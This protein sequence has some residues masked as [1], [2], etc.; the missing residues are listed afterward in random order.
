MATAKKTTSKASSTSGAGKKASS[1]KSGSKKT[2]A[3]NTGA[4]K[5][6]AASQTGGVEPV[7]AEQNQT[8]L[9]G[10][11]LMLV[12][13]MLSLWFALIGL[14]VFGAESTPGQML[15]AVPAGLANITLALSAV[16]LGYTLY[17]ERKGRFGA[18]QVAGACFF[19]LAL[20]GLLHLPYFAVE[21]TAEASGLAQAW[22]AGLQG[23]GGSVC[24]FLVALL[25]CWLP[26]QAAPYIVLLA[27]LLLG[28]MLA[29]DMRIFGAAAKSWHKSRLAAR[30]KK[31]AAA[32]AREQAAA[33]AALQGPPKRP[34]RTSFEADDDTGQP[35]HTEKLEITLPPVITEYSGSRFADVPR[36]AYDHVTVGQMLGDDLDYGLPETNPTDEYASIHAGFTTI[37]RNQAANQV[38]QPRP[39]IPAQRQRSQPT[40]A[41]SPLRETFAQLAHERFLEDQ[42]EEFSETESAAFPLAAET[43]TVADNGVELTDNVAAFDEEYLPYAERTEPAAS[44]YM[45]ELNEEIADLMQTTARDNIIAFPGTAAV[46][47]E[48]IEDIEDIEDNAAESALEVDLVDAD[49]IKDNIENNSEEWIEDEANIENGLPEGDIAEDNIED[50]IFEENSVDENNIIEETERQ[51]PKPEPAPVYPKGGEVHTKL[52]R[53]VDYQ[54]P[55]L[56]LMKGGIVVKNPRINQRIMDDSM[57]LEQVLASFGV[58]TKVVEVVCGPSII[59]Y[60]LQPAPGVKISRIVNLADDIA[61]ALAARGLRIEAPVPGKPVVGIEVAREQTSPVYFKDVLSSENFRKSKSKISIA[62]GIDINGSA[63]VGNLAEMPHLLIAGATGSGKS[64]CMNTLIC[65]ILY[66]ARPDEVKMIMIDPKKVEM[67]G[68][69]GLPHLGRPVVTDA[70]KAAQVLKEIVNEMDRRYL[71]FVDAGVKNFVTYNELPDVVKLPQIVVLID[72]LADLMMV[73]SKDVEESICRL[74]Q[75]AR[76]AG[77]H[78]V[79]ATQRP[80]VDVI[81]GLIKANVPSRIAFAVSSQIDSRTILDMGGAEKLLGKGDMLYYPIGQQKPLRVQ[82]AFLTEEEIHDLVAYCKE[83]AK[84]EYLELPEVQE[85]AAEERP[86]EQAKPRFDALFI[87]ACQQIISSGQA[88]ASSL[89]RRFSIGYNRAARLIDTMQE[90]GIVSAPAG[91][92]RT[93]LMDMATFEALYVNPPA[94]TAEEAEPEE[95]EA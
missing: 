44:A 73:A 78:L 70:K 89:Q 59:R 32:A 54:L 25:V 5:T 62:L 49:L 11:G 72:E 30:E 83:Q 68:Y 15:L 34:T 10:V 94:A 69:T 7:E 24:G 79:I 63:I 58:K 47:N 37:V 39:A 71:V 9:V 84:P 60:E 43:E 67:T 52:E 23:L 88:S 4:K 64:V 3:K 33:E 46:D 35:W 93:V 74:A 90:E 22:Q 55:P 65:S 48:D 20:V 18:W 57:R 85:P 6:K 87:D 61:L 21:P 38:V 80:S 77:I 40:P 56:S 28:I 14:G 27:F 50:E 41:A 51:E 1:S 29:T 19:L 91:N 2:A 12:G 92:K 31:Q 42:A 36:E 16:Y 8:R 76:A 66:K 75:L 17:S 26:G 95:A 53:V 13:L 86:E 82:G 81:T 45:Q